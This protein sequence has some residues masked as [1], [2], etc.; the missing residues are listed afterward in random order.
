M[1]IAAKRLAA[2]TSPLQGGRAFEASS[3]LPYEPQG[4]LLEYAVMGRFLLSLK[5]ERIWRQNYAN[6]DEAIRDIA[7]YI[8]ES[9][10]TRQL[11]SK[12]AYQPPNAFERK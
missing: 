12:L 2:T 10:N 3:K 6:Q 1:A 9:P 5:M 7:D 11:Y 8:I 4:Q